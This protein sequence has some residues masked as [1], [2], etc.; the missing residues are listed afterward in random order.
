MHLGHALLEF[1]FLLG[2]D[3]GHVHLPDEHRILLGFVGHLFQLG[4]LDA[5][6]V[7]PGLVLGHDQVQR[8]GMIVGSRGRFDFRLSSLALLFAGQLSGLFPLQNFELVLA[9]NDAQS[10]TTMISDRERYST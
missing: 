6:G 7:C 9:V 10:N 8:L 5:F 3:F 1:G 2:V 4:Q